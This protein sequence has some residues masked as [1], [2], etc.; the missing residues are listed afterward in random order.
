MLLTVIVDSFCFH[1]WTKLII[2]VGFPVVIRFVLLTSCFKKVFSI[3]QGLH[4]TTCDK[5]G[6]SAVFPQHG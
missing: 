1:S 5:H 6:I 4:N 3:D 2:N